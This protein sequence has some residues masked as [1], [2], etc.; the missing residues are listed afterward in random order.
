MYI[1]HTELTVHSEQTIENFFDNYWVQL[2][3]LRQC[4]HNFFLRAI[5]HVISCT[6]LHVKY[7]TDSATELSVATLPRECRSSHAE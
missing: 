6:K 4:S 3:Q 5:N 1:K 2:D 7:T